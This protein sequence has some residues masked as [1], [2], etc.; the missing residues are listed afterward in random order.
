VYDRM[1]GLTHEEMMCG[2]FQLTAFKAQDV[3]VLDL[4]R[5]VKQV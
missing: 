5:P 1:R 3:G 4:L 2:A